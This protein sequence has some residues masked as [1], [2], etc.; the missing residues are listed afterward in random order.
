MC[1]F[2]N[3]KSNLHVSCEL[4]Y[5]GLISTNWPG[6]LECVSKEPLIYIDG[7]HNIDCIKRVCEFV[8]NLSINHKRV[9]ISISDD[10]DKANMIDL[11]DKTFDELVFTKYSYKRSASDNELFELSNSSNKLIIHDMNDVIE[12]CYDNISEFTLFIGSLYLI[13]EIRPMILNYNKKN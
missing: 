9:V 6:R 7:G 10:K 3:K 4:L 12:Y 5:E 8:S 2:L 13:S 11:L 1:A